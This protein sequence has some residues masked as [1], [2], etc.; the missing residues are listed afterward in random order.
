[1]LLTCYRSRSGGYVVGDGGVG[2]IVGV[3]V[4]VDGGGVVL[5]VVAVVGVVDVAVEVKVVIMLFFFI[6]VLVFV[7]V[8][9]LVLVLALV[10]LLSACLPCF[11]R[12]D[13]FTNYYALSNLLLLDKHW[14]FD[15]I[16]YEKKPFFSSF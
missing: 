13:V 3:G 7:F 9:V 1:V 16:L 10:L 5:G 6:M 4:V 11:I 2:A 8:L 12:V 15:L 14:I